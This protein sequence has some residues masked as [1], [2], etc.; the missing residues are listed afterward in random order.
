LTLLSLQ[1]RTA[2]ATVVPFVAFVAPRAFALDLTTIYDAVRATSQQLR[3]MIAADRDALIPKIDADARAWLGNTRVAAVNPVSQTVDFRG[4]GEDPL[5]ARGL[6][7]QGSRHDNI[8]PPP[9]DR[10]YIVARGCGFTGVVR[11]AHVL[12]TYLPPD[13]MVSDDVGLNTRAQAEFGWL[14]AFYAGG[15]AKVYERFEERV[16]PRHPK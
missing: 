7:H 13:V 11:G 8:R 1:D 15:C 5:S 12:R 6:D 3:Y 16:V 10:Y 2:P 14:C 4:D 9:S